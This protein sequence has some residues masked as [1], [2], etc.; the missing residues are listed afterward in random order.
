M[1]DGYALV[2]GLN[3]SFRFRDKQ[4]REV[5]RITLLGTKLPNSNAETK[6]PLLPYP[7]AEQSIS[8]ARGD[9]NA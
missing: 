5:V 7:S 2:N 3:R 8:P 9:S 1:L 4:A 6:C